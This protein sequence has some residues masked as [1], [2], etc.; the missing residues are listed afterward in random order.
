MSLGCLQRLYSLFAFVEHDS[1]IL[2]FLV[3]Q[4]FLG[5]FLHQLIRVYDP[6]LQ[7]L[8]FNE[9]F[10]SPVLYLYQVTM[11]LLLLIASTEMGIEKL[12][13]QG[14]LEILG[15]CEFLTQ[16][17]DVPFSWIKGSELSSKNEFFHAIL[18]AVLHLL[19][20][21]VTQPGR[22]EQFAIE[23]VSYPTLMSRCHS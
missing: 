4:N 9:S 2:D 22:Y 10:V 20:A 12:L 13:Q 16:R 14:C 18:F 19:V 1:F 8:L 6:A 5:H 23:K 15:K 21:F 11:G 17:P 3:K 7:D